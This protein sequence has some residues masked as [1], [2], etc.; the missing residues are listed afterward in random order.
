MLNPRNNPGNQVNRRL[1][2]GLPGSHRNQV[3]H[4]ILSNH[5]IPH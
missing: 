3:N 5:R 2:N 4:G 1:V